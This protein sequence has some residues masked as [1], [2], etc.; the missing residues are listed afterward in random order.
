MNNMVMGPVVRLSINKP[1]PFLPSD[2]NARE[3]EERNK[4]ATQEP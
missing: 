3:R 1:E 4:N 2:E